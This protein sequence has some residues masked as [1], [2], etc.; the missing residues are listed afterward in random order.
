MTN[1]ENRVL[2]RKGARVVTEIEA[3][4][5]NAGIQT[6]TICT[7]GGPAGADGDLFTGDCLA[8]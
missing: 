7:V 3:T 1:S 4:A 5:V 8:L 6:D 2:G